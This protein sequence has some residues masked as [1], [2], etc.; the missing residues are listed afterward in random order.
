LN[1]R[2]EERLAERTRIAHE[3]H[4]TLLQG[5]LSASMQL[6]MAAENVPENSIAKGQLNQILDLMRRVTEEGRNTLR[7]LRASVDGR[8]SLENALSS[9]PSEL[10][11]PKE[12]NYRVVV[13]GLVRAL[14]PVI[15]D[16][17]YCIGREALSNAVR[18]AKAS[19]IE[20]ELEYT[21]MN[22]LMVV[23]DNGCGIDS[24]VLESGKDGHWGLLGMQ[25]RA[26][27]IGADLKLF[28]RSGAGTEVELAVPAK[29]AYEAVPRDGW[30]RR[31]I[32]IFS[33]DFRIK[34]GRK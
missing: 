24:V 33:F 34:R 14:H 7:G 6:H 13:D 23:R 28:S 19:S 11:I 10:C 17:V 31:L 27:A 21:A 5:F 20:V 1:T 30:S 15:R 22:L 16:E 29:I 4:D 18:H 26:E 8:A 32:D 3:L 12:T 9:I 2:F 25:E